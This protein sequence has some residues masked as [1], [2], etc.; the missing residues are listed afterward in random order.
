V[1]RFAG[2]L[3]DPARRADA[4]RVFD[5][6]E[7]Q[8]ADFYPLPFEEPLRRGDRAASLGTGGLHDQLIARI[9][10][11]RRAWAGA[12]GTGAADAAAERMRL[13]HRLTTIMAETEALLAAGEDAVVLNRWAAWELGPESFA[14]L[15]ADLGTRLKLATTAAIEGDDPGLREQL[16]RIPAVPA[17]L[18]SRLLET[19]GPALQQLPSGGPATVGQLVHR[20]S[21]DAYLVHRD[22]ALA[23]VCRYEMELQ[24]ARRTGRDDLA[25]RLTEYVDMLCGELLKEVGP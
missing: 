16:D 24:H 20:P 18:V 14:R 19:C 1:R 9:E 7:T 17:A 10:Q 23:D 2:W 11:D 15:T 13:L 8:L 21:T 22:R 12:W 6:I 25:E 3:T 5:D 4:V